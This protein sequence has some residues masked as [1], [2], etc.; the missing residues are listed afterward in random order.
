MKITNVEARDIYVSF[1]LSIGEINHLLNFLDKS[2]VEF[3]SK[4][5]PEM[6]EA[7]KFV[8]EEFFKNL[9]GLSEELKNGVGPNSPGS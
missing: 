4:D 8:R 7:D 9:D 1:D 6:V 3:N 2:T 5:N